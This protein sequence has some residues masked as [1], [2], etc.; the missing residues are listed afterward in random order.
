MY[1]HKSIST[2]IYTVVSLEEYSIETCESTEKHA[3]AKAIKK[4]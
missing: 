3:T 2:Y 1:I 4:E